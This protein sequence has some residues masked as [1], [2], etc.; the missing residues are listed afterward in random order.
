MCINMIKNTFLPSGFAMDGPPFTWRRAFPLLEGAEERIG[1]L[2]PQQIGGFVQ[3]QRR[4]QQI[5]L[6]EFTPGFFHQ[7]LERNAL[8]R[9]PPLQGACTEAQFRRDILQSRPLARQEFLQ[10]SLH[11]S[12]DRSL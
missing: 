4:M 11:L 7:V 2:V 1:V 5:M 8:R 12:S 9:E 10:N 6:R 3:L